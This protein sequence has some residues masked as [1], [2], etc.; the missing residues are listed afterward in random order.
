MHMTVMMLVLILS[1]LLPG[2]C[3]YMIPYIQ[4]HW[5]CDNVTAKHTIK[6]LWVA[7]ADRTSLMASQ[8]QSTYEKLIIQSYTTEPAERVYYL[9]QLGAQ[10]PQGDP[11]LIWHA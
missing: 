4:Q 2:F 8:G 3:I 9:Q 1:W 11:L 6:T 5:C 10:W 7:D